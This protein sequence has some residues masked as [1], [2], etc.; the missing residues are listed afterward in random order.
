MVNFLDDNLNPSVYLD[1]DYL[2]ELS[3]NTFE[4]LLYQLISHQLDLTALTERYKNKSVVRK[5]YIIQHCCC[6]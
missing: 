6:V 1:I 2:E 5:P 3:E 4:F